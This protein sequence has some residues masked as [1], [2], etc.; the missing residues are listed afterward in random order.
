M[1]LLNSI[2]CRRLFAINAIVS[3]FGL[4]WDNDHRAVRG[5]SNVGLDVASLYASGVNYPTPLSIG[6]ERLTC[7]L[8]VDVTV[9][10]EALVMFL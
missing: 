8:A 3:K 10:Q 7:R 4:L 1:R 2:V 6:L 5:I 9:L